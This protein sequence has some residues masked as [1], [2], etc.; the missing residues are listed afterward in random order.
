MPESKPELPRI[1]PGNPFHDHL[2]V[3]QRCAKQPNNLCQE[4]DII[5]RE[6]SGVPLESH[7]GKRFFELDDNGCDWSFVATDLIHAK[8]LLQEGVGR[9]SISLC[10][11][12]DKSEEPSWSEIPVGRA[13]VL[14]TVDDDAGEGRTRL[15]LAERNLGDFFSSEW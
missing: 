12:L 1:D 9:G 15:P 2:D 5:L 11:G 3:C 7:Q 6:A 10:A 14:M 4:G 8:R 13:L